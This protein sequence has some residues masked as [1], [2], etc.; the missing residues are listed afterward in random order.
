MTQNDPRFAL[1]LSQR[2]LAALP[3]LFRP[4]S[5]TVQAQHTGVARPASVALTY[6]PPAVKCADG[7]KSV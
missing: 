3:H 2:Q 6:P 5:L 1:D 4:V 7:L